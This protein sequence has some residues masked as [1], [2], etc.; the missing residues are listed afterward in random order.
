MYPSFYTPTD[1]CLHSIH[2]HLLSLR[3]LQTSRMIA[4]N[5]Q[6]HI[7]GYKFMS[8]TDIVHE[9]R[10]KKPFSASAVFVFDT[11]ESVH[12][13]TRQKY[14]FLL[15]S[16][17][18][19]NMKKRKYAEAVRDVSQNMERI[20]DFLMNIDLRS[21]QI[22]VFHHNSQGIQDLTPQPKY[23][24]DL[25]PID[26]NSGFGSKLLTSVT[27]KAGRFSNCSRLS[28]LGCSGCRT[29]VMTAWESF[30]AERIANWQ[31]IAKARWQ[32]TAGPVNL[33]RLKL[34]RCL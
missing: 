17:N 20:L 2:L 15:V 4:S 23:F 1:P 29:Q 19:P 12:K 27:T 11:I 14:K 16:D 26:K 22:K 33:V 5:N 3:S 7:L 10:F 30:R 34:A 31:A 21:L 28:H 18:R 9:E 8:E 13:S 32:F 24:A 25:L 6:K